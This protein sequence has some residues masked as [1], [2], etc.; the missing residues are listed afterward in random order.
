MQSFK[1]VIENHRENK[2]RLKF[3]FNRFQKE[4]VAA[5]EEIQK[6]KREVERINIL[7]ESVTRERDEERKRNADATNMVEIFRK[8]IER[9]KDLNESVKSELEKQKYINAA[10]MEEVEQLKRECKNL[11]QRL[12]TQ[13]EKYTRLINEA[14]SDFKN[15]FEKVIKERDDQ[16]LINV[17]AIEN[18]EMLKREN[19]DL[20]QQNKSLQDYNTELKYQVD[21][22]LQREENLRREIKRHQIDLQRDQLDDS[23]ATELQ[24]KLFINEIRAKHDSEKR[25][26]INRLVRLINCKRFQTLIKQKLENPRMNALRLCRS[27][28]CMSTPQDI[29]EQMKIMKHLKEDL[30]LLKS[31]Y[32]LIMSIITGEFYQITN[33]FSKSILAYEGLVQEEPIMGAIFEVLNKL[34]EQEKLDLSIDT[35]N[36]KIKKLQDRTNPY[37]GTTN[38][39]IEEIITNFRERQNKKIRDDVACLF[40]IDES[41]KTK[42][43]IMLEYI[44]GIIDGVSVTQFSEVDKI[45]LFNN[46]NSIAQTI[47]REI[48]E[49]ENEYLEINSKVR[50][51]H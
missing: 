12:E 11:E 3:Q 29:I 46:I 21:E 39:K 22:Q 14:E 31:H 24:V 6:L 33:A 16:I 28:C 27:I 34:L 15:R 32:C 5:M 45:E 50:I 1:R 35:M 42:Y 8:K 38:E 18:T 43:Q 10:A 9:V 7:C 17:N 48:G 44:G 40:E 51:A 13:K 47:E 19:K 25:L 49:T 36:Q 37:I 30:R 41:R 20:K 23:N 2:N 26:T 4:L